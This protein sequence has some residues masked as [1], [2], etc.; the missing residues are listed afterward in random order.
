MRAT[1]PAHPTGS[2]GVPIDP[3]KE[4]RDPI[5]SQKKGS[6]KGLLIE[7]RLNTLIH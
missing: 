2:K 1:E 5:E 6:Q 3:Q 4:Q 7:E